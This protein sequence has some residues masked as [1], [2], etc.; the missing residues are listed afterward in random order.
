VSLASR[1][2]QL[3]QH[4]SNIDEELDRLDHEDRERQRRLDIND[5]NDVGHPEPV[6]WRALGWVA[7]FF[8]GGGVVLLS[9]ILHAI[10]IAKW[11]Y[12]IVTG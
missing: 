5:F 11:V 6:D 7:M 12:H 4:L 10:D 8:I 1:R 2:E 9:L 3:N